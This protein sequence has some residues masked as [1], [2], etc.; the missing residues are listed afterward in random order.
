[1][2][3]A[4]APT[5]VVTPLRDTPNSPG[6][7]DVGVLDSLGGAVDGAA[8]DGDPVVV[9]GSVADEQPDRANRAVAVAVTVRSGWLRMRSIYAP[10]VASPTGGGLGLAGEGPVG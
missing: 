8:V 4:G 9:G 7:T 1:M 2:D 3:S 10:N 6:A 5:A